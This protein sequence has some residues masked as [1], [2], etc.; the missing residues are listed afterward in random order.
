MAATTP[1]PVKGKINTSGRGK[2]AV[3]MGGQAPRAR[4]GARFDQF[5][6]LINYDAAGQM[7]PPGVKGVG[8]VRPSQPSDAVGSTGGF[9][10]DWNQRF[11][12]NPDGSARTPAPAPPPVVGRAAFAPARPVGPLVGPTP[13]GGTLDA[14]TQPQ[15]PAPGAF[16]QPQPGNPSV[17][18][19]DGMMHTLTPTRGMVSEYDPRQD[20]TKRAIHEEDADPSK[21]TRTLAIPEKYGGGSATGKN[22]GGATPAVNTMAP[23]QNDAEIAKMLDLRGAAPAMSP[24][25]AQLQAAGYQQQGAFQMPPPVAPTPVAA[26]PTPQAAPPVAFPQTIPGIPAAPAPQ[27]RAEISAPMVQAPSAGP[28]LTSDIADV[29]RT[30]LNVGAAIGNRLNSSKQEYQ[31]L[32]QT[33]QAGNAAMA[34]EYPRKKR[35]VAFASPY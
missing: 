30:A 7:T 24:E 2:T 1:A 11:P 3:G 12:N 20:T 34:K 28:T 33:L 10:A 26:T 8:A 19:Q 14:A 29:T 23:G 6:R 21:F 5:G 22:N 9:S 15:A 31:D 4:I 27:G 32:G 17:S 25:A 18:G 35:P 16:Q 13:S